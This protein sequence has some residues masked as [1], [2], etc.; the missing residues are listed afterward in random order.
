VG[1][2]EPS[3]KDGPGRY[4]PVRDVP[5]RDVPGRLRVSR[6]LSIP[7]GELS[8]R[9]GPSGGPGGQHANKTSSR[10][11]LTFDVAGSPSLG[12]RQ[13]ARLLERLG[14]VVRVTAG[15]ERSQARN[16]DIALQ[17]LGHKLAA[18][19]AT[20]PVR[21]ETKPTTA[22][23]ERRLTAKHRRSEVKRRRAA[24]GEGDD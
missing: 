18:A 21:R 3:G 1:E 10:V 16:R 12:P 8:W 2:G 17:R 15:D 19:L 11:V 9:A 20:S 6:T 14:P 24:A 5:A 22:S 13:R 7:L 23:R 4:P